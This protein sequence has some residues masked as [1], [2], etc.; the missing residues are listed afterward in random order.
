[1]PAKLV[2]KFGSYR[3]V[4]RYPQDSTTINYI[5]EIAAKDG[6]GEESWQFIQA[7]NKDD[8]KVPHWIL[9]LFRYIEEENDD[10]DEF[11]RQEERR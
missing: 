7:L 9:E 2:K 3:I 11:L 8:E 10:E 1:M 6:M 5:V 4:N